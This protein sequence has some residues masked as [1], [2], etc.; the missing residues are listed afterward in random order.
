MF[1]CCQYI[2][3]KFITAAGEIDKERLE[4]I[5]PKD[6]QFKSKPCSCPCHQDGVAMMC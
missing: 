5:A 2:L 1:G 3:Q 6:D 4:K